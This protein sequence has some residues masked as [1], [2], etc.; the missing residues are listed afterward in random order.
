VPEYRSAIF[1]TSPEQEKTARQV[2]DEVQE[3]HFKGK[4][5]VTVIAPAG[6]WYDAEDY[7]QRYLDI[8]PH[9]YEC[10]YRRLSP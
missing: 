10:A 7:H 1:T 9:G 4:K 8:N 2:T 5:I 6:E 3:Q